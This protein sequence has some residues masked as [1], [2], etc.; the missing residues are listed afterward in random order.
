MTSMDSVNIEINVKENIINIPVEKETNV[1]TPKPLRKG[2][3][4]SVKL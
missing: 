4:W 1:K 3:Q 2:T